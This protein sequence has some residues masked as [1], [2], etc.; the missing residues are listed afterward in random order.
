MVESA[1]WWGVPVVAGAFLLIGG[2]LTFLFNF[3][4]DR[5]RARRESRQRWDGALLEA[6]AE[7]LQTAQAIAIGGEK[8]LFDLS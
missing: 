5:A 7:L 3:A 6:G 2:L 8:W 4:L 1:P